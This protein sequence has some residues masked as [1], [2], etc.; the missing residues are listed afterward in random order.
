M[1]Y[2]V[3]FD[4]SSVIKQISHANKFGKKLTIFV[5]NELMCIQAE[6]RLFFHLN[7]IHNHSYKKAVYTISTYV[8][9][10]FYHSSE[11]TR[12]LMFIGSTNNKSKRI[13]IIQR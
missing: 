6:T 4:I 9:T 1:T 13:E 10:I 7:L 2:V 12:N 8:H 5:M 3:I 11:L